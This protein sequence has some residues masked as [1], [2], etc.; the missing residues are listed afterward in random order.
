MLRPGRSFIFLKQLPPGGREPSTRAG[1]VLFFTDTSGGESPGRRRQIQSPHETHAPTHKRLARSTHKSSER[2]DQEGRIKGT[3]MG[4]PR[5]RWCWIL[6]HQKEDGFET[7][8]KCI[9]VTLITKGQGRGVFFFLIS[10]LLG[11]SK[12]PRGIFVLVDK[13]SLWGGIRELVLQAENE[14]GGRHQTG[15]AKRSSLRSQVYSTTP[16]NSE[17][18]S[19]RA[20]EAHV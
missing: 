2:R 19:S 17:R 16:G 20:R 6:R 10:T 13:R 12:Y 4:Q 3:N 15:G 5:P 7:H 18:T 8:S 14:V 11:K 1:F 9:L